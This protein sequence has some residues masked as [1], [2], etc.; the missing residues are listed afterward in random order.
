MGAR[1]IG[2]SKAPTFGALGSRT[3]SVSS[4][5]TLPAD[6]LGAERLPLAWAVTSL[7]AGSA[8]A[9]PRAGA[10]GALT[11]GAGA[12]SPLDRERVADRVWGV[13]IDASA[14][15][16]AT[17]EGVRIARANAVS[18]DTTPIARTV[19]RPRGVPA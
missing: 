12:T 6:W 2:T 10:G 4:D 16:T 11:S 1:S 14:R 17:S 15:V 18:R 19:S 7:R 9:V 5:S 3:G 13:M 8:D